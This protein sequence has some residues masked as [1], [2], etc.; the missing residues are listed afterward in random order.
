MSSAMS[1]FTPSQQAAR[2]AKHRSRQRTNVIALTLAIGAMAFGL[3]W[4]LWILFETF[5]IGR[6][7]V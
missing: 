6:A 2:L 5:Q 1:T 4:L 3:F 7:H